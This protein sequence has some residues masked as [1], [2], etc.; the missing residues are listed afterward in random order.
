VDELPLAPPDVPLA[1]PL[2]PEAPMSV[3]SD[4][5]QANGW[6]ERHAANKAPPH[7]TSFDSLVRVFK[8]PSDPG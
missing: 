1:P 4:P 6:I 5:P 2:P 8:L 7:V 3:A